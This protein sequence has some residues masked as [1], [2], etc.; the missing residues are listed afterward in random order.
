VTAP[1]TESS[2]PLAPPPRASRAPWVLLLLLLGGAVFLWLTRIQ[3]RFTNR[4]VA[5]VRLIAGANRPRVVA[6][7]ESITLWPESRGVLLVQWDLVQPLS[8]DSTSMGV[9][10]HGAAVLR[11]ARGVIQQEAGSRVSDADY[12][13][14]LITN[15]TSQYLRVTVNAGL[16][17]AVDCGCAV[18]PGAQRAFIGYYRLYQ[19]STVRARG[20]AGAAT[21]QDLGPK[22]SARGG[23]VGLRFENKDLKGSE[24]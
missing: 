14:P 16:V 21:F 8:A 12:F 18:R 10:V 23:A 5:P 4:L 22:V 17:G 2:L 13:A 3:L 15:A 24:K 7:G 19:N 20:P 6:P 1:I 9:P 11:N